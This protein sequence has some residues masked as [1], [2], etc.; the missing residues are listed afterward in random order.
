MREIDIPVFS[1]AA[2]ELGTPPLGPRAS[3]YTEMRVSL[4]CVWVFE[5]RSRRRCLVRRRCRRS[6]RVLRQFSVF[7]SVFFPLV[8][9][10]PVCGKRAGSRVCFSSQ[11]L[12]VSVADSVA[13]RSFRRN[14]KYQKSTELLIRK[15][16]FQRLVRE[17][18][19]DF[20][21]DLRFQG[22]AVL[23]LQEAAEAY[24]VGLF[25]D[26]NL[27]AIHAKR[28]TIMPKDIQLAR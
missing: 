13:P 24:L 12:G 2:A 6:R 19:Q 17:I 15:L 23:A 3:G 8:L 14:R 4:S 11:I 18:A 26:T 7:I 16:P 9:L 10:Q 22:S 1:R 28:V 20:K 27:C 5:T 21:T 25:E